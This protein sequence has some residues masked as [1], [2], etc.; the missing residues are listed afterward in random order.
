[1]KRSSD[2]DSAG[3]DTVSSGS[4]TRAA[5]AARPNVRLLQPY[6]PS[7]RSARVLLDANEAPTT[8]KRVR[9]RLEER[10]ASLDLNRY[11]SRIRAREVA[12]MLESLHGASES[13]VVMGN[14]SNEILLAIHLAFGGPSRRAVYFEPTYTVY[15]AI[16]A[17]VGTKAVAVPRD[18]SFDISTSSLEQA[19]SYRPSIVHLCSPNN[20]TGNEDPPG[21]AKRVAS[22]FPDALV[23]VDRAYAPF[24][25]DSAEADLLKTGNLVIVRTF[26]KAAGLAGLRIGYALAPKSVGE[27]LE[28]AVLPYNVDAVSL[29]AAAACIEEAES[30]RKQEDE[31]AKE[32]DR[33]FSAI[34]SH[35]ELVAFPSAANFVLFGPRGAGS[36]RKS[37]RSDSERLRL[38]EMAQRIFSFLLE[39]SV[40][41]RDCTSWPGLI[42]CL[43]VSAGLP[44]E[45]DHFITALEGA[46]ARIKP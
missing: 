42:G 31:L 20:P 32:R 39:K 29:E 22:A 37:Y 46:V 10:L 5:P 6:K 28:K 27:M 17:I 44:V 18:E 35:R 19:A 23:V 24:G 21:F 2:S 30:V 1:M 14:G 34:R 40:L 7:L 8:P 9:E 4:I 38:T 43:R 45:T 15:S 41:V 11:P 16:S 26:S 36:A 33:I 13:K 3:S 25:G 12:A